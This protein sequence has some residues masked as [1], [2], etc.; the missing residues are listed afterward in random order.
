MLTALQDS[1]QRLPQLT[2][3]IVR[4]ALAVFLSKSRHTRQAVSGPEE[5]QGAPTWAKHGWAAMLLLTCAAFSEDVGVAV[6]EGLIVE[7]V[8]L[9]HHRLVCE[10]NFHGTG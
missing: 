4:E 5:A 6:R 2:N 9:G 10:S 1:T 7:L 8:V 3:Q